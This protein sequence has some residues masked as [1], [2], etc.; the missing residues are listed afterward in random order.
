MEFSFVGIQRCRKGA[1]G[2][3]RTFGGSSRESDSSDHPPRSRPLHR[4]PRRW[5][6][7]SGGLRLVD[8]PGTTL[9]L[10][11]VDH[12]QAVNTTTRVTRTSRP[13]R[14]VYSCALSTSASSTSAGCA[15]KIEVRLPSGKQCWYR[16]KTDSSRNLRRPRFNCTRT[17]VRTCR[18]DGNHRYS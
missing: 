2:P 4:P 17:I 9:G 11:R 8:Y 1:I 14:S 16:N 10:R 18:I 12:Q 7:H 3:K 6:K 5:L 13:A 15:S